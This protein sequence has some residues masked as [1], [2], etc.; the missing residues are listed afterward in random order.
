L[1]ILAVIARTRAA[2]PQLPNWKFFLK[3]AGEDNQMHCD[4]DSSEG[5][6]KRPSILPGGRS[7]L[8]RNTPHLFTPDSAD[9]GSLCAASKI[10]SNHSKL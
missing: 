9:A 2:E 10:L 6:K 7:L 1:S 8:A 5:I 4:P 3:C